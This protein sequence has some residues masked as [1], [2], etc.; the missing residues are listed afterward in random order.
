MGQSDSYENR[1]RLRLWEE[2]N[3]DDPLDRRCPYT[4]EQI[5]LNSVFSAEVEIEHILPFSR[6][7]DDGIGNK[8]LSMRHANRFKGQQTPF[9]AFSLSPKGYDWAEISTRAVNLPKNKSW[10]FNPDAM[11]RYNDSERNFLA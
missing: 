3:P 11:D 4:G 8:T 5:G 1:V 9:E 2:L 6:T 7:L 10:R